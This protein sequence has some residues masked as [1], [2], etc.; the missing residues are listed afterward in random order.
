MTTKF[1][2]NYQKVDN[3]KLFKNLEE[4]LQIEN[5]Q[6][7]IPIYNN[8][9]KINETNYNHINLN[10]N[11]SINK[12]LDS[13][14]DS[15]T[16][17]C[18]IKSFDGNKSLTRSV[19]IKYSPLLDPVKYMIGKY[20]ISNNNLLSLPKLNND[21]S[22][23]KSRELNNSAYVDG[24][25][26]FLT[27]QL[28]HKHKFIHGLDFYGMFL[29]VKNRFIM[30]VIDEVEYLV[31][32]DFFNKNKNILFEFD[33]KLQDELLNN[34]SRNFKKRII[35]EDDI[36]EKESSSENY[37]TLDDINDISD[38]DKIFDTNNDVKYEVHNESKSSQINEIEC[39]NLIDYENI[40]HIESIDNK[41]K[42]SKT[43]RSCSSSGS[44]CSSRTS[45]TSVNEE[46]DINSDDDMVEE[47]E[48]LSVSGSGDEC[49]SDDDSGEECSDDESSEDVI[50]AVVYKFP[51]SVICL[52]KCSNTMDS[53]ILR[54]ELSPKEWTSMLLQV[55]MTLIT[56]QKVFK[57]THNDLHTNNIM[58]IPTE[59]QFLYYKYENKI[60]KVPTYGKIF[61]I[62]DYG[63]A[64]YRYNGVLLC[65]DS[66]S[67]S[68]DA[69]TQYN[70]EPYM[71][72][73]K[74]RIEPNYSFD[75]CRLACSIYDFLK[76]DDEPK[77]KR[78]MDL[79]DDWCKDDKGRNVLYKTNGDERYPEF[80][81]Y[82]MIA[83]TVHK[84]TPQAQLS[85][86]LFSQFIVPKSK[87]SNKV[88]DIMNIDDLPTYF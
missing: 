7:Y 68:G 1:Q 30:N 15:N 39:D 66:F 29:A 59:K 41:M 23:I 61:K 76:I 49:D 32:S 18:D 47:I 87:L 65:S 58:F 46:N 51:V 37:L 80:K 33:D 10:S 60:Y 53:L 50:N 52:E 28:L 71:N 78:I 26:S 22:H 34:T 16:Y 57:F 79:I 45:N 4:F 81:L 83:R 35:I 54:G 2:L 24:F 27:S 64:I 8:F 12:I 67:T 19:F 70:F 74:P 9:F 40:E 84:H 42:I 20:D 44:T 63:R 75:L 36:K 55:I 85:R 17:N 62:I 38:I 11:F 77:N 25:F 6:N 56:Y 88:K 3:D 13:G 69:S 31:D 14:I 43:N 21:N 48:H 72:D 86:D 73:K 5:P 82:K